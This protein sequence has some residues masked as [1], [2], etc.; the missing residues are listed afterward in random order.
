M[1]IEVQG[2][3][4]NTSVARGGAVMCE[5]E[6]CFSTNNTLVFASNLAFRLI[7]YTESVLQIV[8]SDPLQLLKHTP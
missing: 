2:C 6:F 3:S 5:A 8:I 4:H 7:L 1:G